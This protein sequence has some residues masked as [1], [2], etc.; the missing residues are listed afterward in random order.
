MPFHLA[1]IL[2][3]QHLIPVF[4]GVGQI[5]GAMLL[6]RVSDVYGRKVVLV[7]SFTGSIIGYSVRLPTQSFFLSDN[8]KQILTFRGGKSFWSSP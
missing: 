7:I 5:I 8:F 3:E 4:V 1:T 2:F 6:P